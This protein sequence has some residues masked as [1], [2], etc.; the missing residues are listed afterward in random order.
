LK[1]RLHCLEPFRAHS[2]HLADYTAPSPDW[3][4]DHCEGCTA[5]FAEFDAPDIL[6]TGYFTIAQPSGKPSE[7]PEF[8]KQ[9]RESGYKV[10]AKPDAKRW[11]CK[12][13]FEEFRETLAWKLKSATQG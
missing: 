5:E 13:C 4:H 9:S 7:E 2:F 1:N 6:H 10:I 3:D 8:I 12:E 11:V